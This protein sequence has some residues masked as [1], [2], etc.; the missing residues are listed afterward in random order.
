M[1]VHWYCVSVLVGAFL[2]AGC[3]KPAAPPTPES[4]QGAATTAAPSETPATTPGEESPA[5][6]AASAKT[7]ETSP[8][9]AAKP[10][11]TSAASAA[12]K[13]EEKT[14]PPASAEQTFSA[15][16]SGSN[17][18]PA[19][20]T[21]AGGEAAFNVPS[22]KQELH[23]E[24]TVHDVKG[25][26]MAHLH[27]APAGENGPI[28]VWLYPSPTEKK[29]KLIEGVTDGKLVEGT[30]TAADFVGPLKGAPFGDLI[31]KIKQGDIYVNV[32]TTQNPDGELRGKIQ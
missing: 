30:V 8:A 31:D 17:E 4:S 14:K 10:A 20:K 6:Q 3:Q 11:D 7:E 29:E 5:G 23:Y 13:E 27:M 2:V 19:V 22:G 21:D 1:R 16:L 24:L 15:T 28:V 18:V 26:T 9:G 25:V 32:H 12:A